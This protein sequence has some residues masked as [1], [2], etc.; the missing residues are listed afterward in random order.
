MTERYFPHLLRGSLVRTERYEGGKRV[1]KVNGKPIGLIHRQ[2]RMVVMPDGAYGDR[3]GISLAH[4]LERWEHNYECQSF[5][6]FGSVPD[7]RA[8]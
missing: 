3:L 5:Q 1:I 7:Q 8:L 2:G 6:P 4:F